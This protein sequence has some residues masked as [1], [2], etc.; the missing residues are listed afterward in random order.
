M[1][2]KKDAYDAEYKRNNY[3]KI[4]FLVKKGKRAEYQQAAE[5]FGLGQA[6]MI[7]LAVETFIAE[8]SLQDLPVKPAPMAKEQPAEKLTSTEKNLLD[9]FNRLP[10]D[11]QKAF[12]KTFKAINAA[13]DADNQSASLQ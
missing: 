7:R 1:G 5:N 6:E 3:D 4:F 11:V 10:V 8:R 9:E 2:T 12:L 13:Q